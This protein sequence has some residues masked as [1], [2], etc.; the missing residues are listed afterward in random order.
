MTHLQT[1]SKSTKSIAILLGMLGS[2]L[3]MS[4]ANANPAAY[5]VGKYLAVGYD[6][7]VQTPYA[8]HV[9]IEKSDT[10]FLAVRYR[11]MDIDYAGYIEKTK[12]KNHALTLTVYPLGKKSKQPIK[13][14]AQTSACNY[15]HNAGS[16]SAEI[17][18]HGSLIGSKGYFSLVMH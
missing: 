2:I 13:R 12:D 8:H 11:F 7:H 16:M 18:C 10:H 14:S 6:K 1:V 9:Y 17:N 3:I 5:F 15:L 4:A